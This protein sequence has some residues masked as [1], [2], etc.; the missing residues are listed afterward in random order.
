MPG[1][2]PIVV[3]D[4]LTGACEVAAVAHRHGIAA[5]VCLGVVTPQEGDVLSVVDTDT[6]LLP[7]DE[8]ARRVTDCLGNLRRVDN[9]PL[10]FKKVDSVLRGPVA[11]ELRAAAESTGCARALLVPANPA[12]G[13]T[14]EAGRYRIHGTPLHQTD[15]ARDPCHPARTDEVVR[16]LRE[17]GLRP[18]VSLRPGDP[19]PARGLA[20][21]DADDDAD[22]DHWAEQLDNGTL[23]AGSAAF[24]SS[25][26]RRHHGHPEESA[27]DAPPP[28]EG[29]VLLVSG[30]TSAT[31]QKRLAAAF[32]HGHPS[33]RLG[34]EDIDQW[35]AGLRAGLDSSG[36]TAA[37]MAPIDR[38]DPAMAPAVA[39]ALAEVTFRTV[40]NRSPLH[41]IVEGGATAVAV[42]RRLGWTRL[43]VTREWSPGV[44]SL[45]PREAPRATFTLKPGSYPWPPALENLFE[46][47]K[48]ESAAT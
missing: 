23:A 48:P 36:S 45:S 35:T 9:R 46:T 15:F 27:G 43:R 11:A 1:R 30:T 40:S 22:L 21:G 20:V 33:N 2:T 16:I 6:R 3:A 5:E 37:Y 32:G 28:P 47:A 19:L 39:A 8:A 12:L 44:V 18:V 24:F 29:P 42:A 25:V 13:R 31:A 38:P 10:L 34:K 17:G 4:D 26:L 7:P 41:L 14:I